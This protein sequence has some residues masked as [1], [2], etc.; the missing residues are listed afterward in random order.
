MAGLDPATGPM[1]GGWI[2]IV[3]NRPYGPLYVGVAS[4]LARR[5]AEHKDGL[6]PGFTARYGFKM[7]VYAERRRVS[8]MAGLGPA[9]GHQAA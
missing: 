4:N 8:V 5:I 2:Y 1:R 3:T 9:I 6:I 7:L